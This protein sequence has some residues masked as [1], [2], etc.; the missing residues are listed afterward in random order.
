MP[1]LRDVT[2]M[3]AP[4]R[5]RA[6]MGENGAGK[7]TLIRLIAGVVP[8]DAMRVERDG[9]P[10]PL[11]SPADAARAG[12]RFIHQELNVVPGLSVAENVALG[13]PVPRRFGVLVDWPQLRAQARAALDLIGAGHIDPGRPMAGLGTGDR[14]LARIASALL[15][16]P[17]AADPCLYVLDEPTAALTAAESEKLYAAI[18]RLTAAGAAVLFVSHRMNEVMRICDDVTVLRDG[19]HV[20]TAPLRETAQDAVIA[21]MT[22][23]A[24]S[25]AVPP[26]AAPHGTAVVVRAEGVATPALRALDFALAE[27]EILGVAG[28]EGAGQTALMRLLLGLEPLRAGRMTVLGAPPPRSPAR[29]WA[30]WIAYVPRERRAEALM[31]TMPVRDNMLVP[32]WGH[33]GPLARPRAE[34]AR[35]RALAAAVGLRYAGPSQFAGELSGGNQQKVVLARAMA[36]RPRLML[37]EEPTRGVDVGARAEIHALIRAQSAGGCAVILASSDLPELIG[38]A[39]RLLILHA[40]RQAALIDRGAM[41]P[42]D[43]LARIYAA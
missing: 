28:L 23:R 20:L 17:G 7:S 37:L 39:D 32:H 36:G 14:M 2:L 16:V 38:L 27:G 35:T 34:A 10:V 30:W 11:R 4:G 29:A 22:G 13:H 1:A 8:A 9:A 19:R 5:V 15:P 3:L 26:R 21:A 43:L 42:A 12:F 6:L 24:V 41:T 40:G 33:H 18:A 31:L 25:D